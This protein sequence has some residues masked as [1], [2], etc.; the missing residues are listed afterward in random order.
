MPS[1]TSIFENCSIRFQKDF[2]TSFIVWV[3]FQSTDFTLV[4]RILIFI[5]N[6]LCFEAFFVVAEQLVPQVY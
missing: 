5:D 6:L 1:P 2:P 3:T 4:Y